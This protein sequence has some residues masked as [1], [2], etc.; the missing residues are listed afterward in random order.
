MVGVDMKGYIYNKDK[1][2]VNKILERNICKR[3]TLS[4]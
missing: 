2:Y 1:D 3:W 4:L